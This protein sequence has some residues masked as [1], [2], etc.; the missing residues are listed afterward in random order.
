[1]DEALIRQSAYQRLVSLGPKLDWTSWTLTDKCKVVSC[2]A[3]TAV[4]DRIAGPLSLVQQES[5]S[6]KG[7]QQALDLNLARALMLSSRSTEAIEKFKQLEASGELS[8][9]HADDCCLIPMHLFCLLANVYV[10]SSNMK[11]THN[12]DA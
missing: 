10:S 11:I 3:G 1:V 2:V 5:V 9:L 6:T 12:K 8:W 4:K 7:V